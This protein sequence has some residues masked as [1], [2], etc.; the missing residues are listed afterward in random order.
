MLYEIKNVKQYK[1]EGLRRWFTD[2]DFDLIVWYDFDNKNID[3]FQLCYDKSNF[4]R[5][6][7]WTRADNIFFHNKIDDGEIPGAI[8]QTPILVVDGLFEVVKVKVQDYCLNYRMV[9][10]KCKKQGSMMYSPFRRFLRS[11][12][13]VD[14]FTYK[15]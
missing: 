3:G 2:K 7:T 12:G 14:A 4:E 13:H 5:A 8:K 15:G 1:N 10:Q 6:L 9:G 11:Q